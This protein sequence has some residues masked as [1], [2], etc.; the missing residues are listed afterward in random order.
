MFMG[1]MYGQLNRLT[2]ISA[3]RIHRRPYVGEAVNGSG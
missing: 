3:L 1:N 2:F